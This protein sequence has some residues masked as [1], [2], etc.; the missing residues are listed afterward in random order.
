MI[1]H[2]RAKTRITAYSASSI[3]H[4]ISNLKDIETIVTFHEVADHLMTL[5]TWGAKPQENRTSNVKEKDTNVVDQQKSLSNVQKIDWRKWIDEAKDLKTD[6]LYNDFHHKIQECLEF[7][8]KKPAK[9]LPIQPWMK[10]SIL[11]QKIELEKLRKIFIKKVR[12]K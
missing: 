1:Q 7:E 3:D 11:R 5:A 9:L 12:E 8:V 10:E 2:V 6:D 4:V